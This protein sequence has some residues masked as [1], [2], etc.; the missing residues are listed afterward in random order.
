MSLSTEKTQFVTNWHRMPETTTTAALRV[1]LGHHEA[2]AAV[3]QRK[4]LNALQARV[5]K[6]NPGRPLHDD[7]IVEICFKGGVIPLRT[8]VR[9][10]PAAL[11]E[12]CGWLAPM[13]SYHG[14]RFWLFDCGSVDTTELLGYG[15]MAELK[16]RLALAADVHVNLHTPYPEFQDEPE[17]NYNAAMIGPDIPI[18][19]MAH[20]TVCLCALGVENRLACEY[21]Q[22]AC[23]SASIDDF[24]ENLAD[25]A[26]QEFPTRS[27]LPPVVDEGRAL[28]EVASAMER[29]VLMIAEAH[30]QALYIAN[31]RSHDSNTAERRVVDPEHDDPPK[32]YTGAARLCL[33]VED[34][35]RLD[36]DTLFSTTLHLSE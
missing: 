30:K 32:K 35:E 36:S 11:R 33:I 18:E 4:A 29:A 19:S 31:Y 12:V 6:G 25:N 28:A 22:P 34:D 16:E 15:E 10:L 21:L 7:D 17:P 24:V 5:G 26:R 14:R 23:W 13:C 2:Q 3:K 27:I 8:L 20:Y 9:H 1:L